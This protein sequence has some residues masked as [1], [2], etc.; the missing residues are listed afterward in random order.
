M[1]IIQIIYLVQKSKNIIAL[2]V[3]II[4]IYGKTIEH[5][6]FKK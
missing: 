3:S 2:I 1:V 5:V 4:Q 6:H